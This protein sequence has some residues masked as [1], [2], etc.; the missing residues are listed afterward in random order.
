MAV[1]NVTVTVEHTFELDIPEDL[2]EE[3]SWDLSSFIYDSFMDDEDNW[4]SCDID[5][6]EIRELSNG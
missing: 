3:D 1:R 4:D 6:N 2:L 5:I